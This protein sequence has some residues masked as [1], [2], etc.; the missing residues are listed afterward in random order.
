[1]FLNPFESG[2]AGAGSNRGCPICDGMGKTIQFNWRIAKAQPSS[3][4]GGYTQ[5]LPMKQK[6]KAGFLY[7]CAV[8][9]EQ[10]YLDEPQETIVLIPRDR[11]ALVAEWGSGPISLPV[12]LWEKAKVIGATAAHSVSGEKEFAEIPCEVHTRQG[13]RIDKCLLTF[14]TAPP[15]ASYQIRVRLMKDVVDIFPS[16]FALP[17]EV[18]TASGFSNPAPMGRAATWVESADGKR[19]CLNW[20][21]NFFDRSKYQGEEIRLMKKNKV[22]PKGRNIWVEEPT[23]KITF[24]IGDWDEKVREFFGN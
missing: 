11:A 2:S 22:T 12:H 20:V 10:W 5:T 1:M 19:F 14:K 8:C 6:L 3:S 13:E 17:K 4:L 18:R 23:K 7:E 16:R 9:G 15:L 21:V 24:F